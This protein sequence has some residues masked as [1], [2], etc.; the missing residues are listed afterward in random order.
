M[1]FFY[2]DTLYAINVSAEKNMFT[3][4]IHEVHLYTCTKLVNVCYVSG[5]SGELVR[6]LV[7]IDLKKGRNTHST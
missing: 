7:A 2:T 5:F 1:G 6:S 3:S 4:F